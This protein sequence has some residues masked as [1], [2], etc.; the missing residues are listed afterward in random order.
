M[1][2]T[3]LLVGIGT[4][5]LACFAQASPSITFWHNLSPELLNALCH[6]FTKQTGIAVNPKWYRGPDYAPALLNRVAADTLPD[7]ALMPA[8][9]LALDR[10][11]RF[12]PIP[13]GLQSKSILPNTIRAGMHGN[14][15]L[16]APTT[17]GNHLMLYYNRD[18]VTQPA[19]TFAELEKQAT[20]LNAKGIKPLGFNFNEMYWF[21]PFM[22]AYGGWPLNEKGELTLN[23]HATEEA[24]EFYFSLV[25]KGLTPAD[26]DN[27]CSLQRFAKGEFAYSIG[28]DWMYKELSEKLGTRFGV[29]TLPNI[30]TRTL[31]PMYTSYLLT[32]P[33]HSLE[34]PKR[35]QLIK[36][37]QFMQSPAIQRR[38]AKEGGLLPVDTVVFNETISQADANKQN[39]LRQLRQA[40]P[41]PNERMMA[42]AWNGMAKGFTAMKNGRVDAEK[43]GLLMQQQAQKAARLA[44]D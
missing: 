13:P 15:L 9:M 37:L 7:V 32:F 24:L 35:A 16:G 39:L 12:S 34:G 36:F 43:A 28:G 6:T 11:L 5:L 20:A 42:H 40:R 8:D 2:F 38:W 41:M 44:G 27:A 23:T 18:Y 10:E 31:K 3:T 30:G 21:V 19:A 25:S 1:K 4:L 26:C 14:I 22:G 33:N 17:W 29:A